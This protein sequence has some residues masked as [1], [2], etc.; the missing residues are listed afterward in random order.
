VVSIR[1]VQNINRLWALVS[2]IMNLRDSQK[3]E[4][5]LTL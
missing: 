4:N 5:F 3:A 2:N 1:E